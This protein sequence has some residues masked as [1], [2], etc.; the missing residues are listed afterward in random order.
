MERSRHQHVGDAEREPT[1]VSAPGVNYDPSGRG[2]TVLRGGAGF[3]AGPPAYV[4]YRNVYGTAGIRALHIDCEGDVVPS[5]H[6]RPEDQPTD[7]A[8]PTPLAFPLSD[9]RSRLP[10]SPQFKVAARYGS[11]SARWGRG[12]GGCPVLSPR[13]R[14]RDG[15]TLNLRGPVGVRPAKEAGCSTGQSTIRPVM[16]HPGPA[17]GRPDVESSRCATAA[18]IAR[19]PSP[20]NSKSTSPA[21]P[22]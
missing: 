6:P 12:H 4:W 22:K 8:Q 21:A 13:E 10:V 7:C 20:P 19:T 3:F 9:P 17:D 15:R 5:V 11:S 18:A 16:R 14:R 2:I 1:L